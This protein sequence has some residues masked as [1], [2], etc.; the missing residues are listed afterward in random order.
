MRD[1]VISI[2]SLKQK[3]IEMQRGDV[4]GGGGGGR[5]TFWHRDHPSIRGA[6]FSR[7]ETLKVPALCAPGRQM[8][9]SGFL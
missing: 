8:A 4:G 9:V 3:L 5:H 1:D 2:A 7:L 6:L